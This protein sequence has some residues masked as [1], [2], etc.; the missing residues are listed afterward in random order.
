[1]TSGNL[2]GEEGQ[3]SRVGPNTQVL[4]TQAGR[5]LMSVSLREDL[6]T[7]YR[8]LKVPPGQ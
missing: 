7:C 4:P 8:G 1:M 6:G 2:A 5:G 3:V